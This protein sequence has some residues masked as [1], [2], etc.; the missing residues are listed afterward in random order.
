MSTATPASTPVRIPWLYLGGLVTLLVGFA[1]SY[2]GGFFL[3]GGP[4]QRLPQNKLPYLAWIALGVAVFA[5]GAYL[6][7]RIDQVRGPE[8]SLM[9]VAFIM[10]PL[11]ALLAYLIN[12]T[13]NYLRRTSATTLQMILISVGI[14]LL[15]LGGAWAW[16]NLQ[17]RV[18]R[19]DLRAFT[20][21]LL[22]DL[23]VVCLLLA[24]LPFGAPVV[25]ANPATDQDRA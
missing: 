14:F 8:L 13:G 6:L 16:D 23:G 25:P 15:A 10:M 2:F 12:L 17:A 5:A 24:A 9:V 3:N 18:V 11:P 22:A 4:E 1:I 19:F 20:W 7:A 21:P